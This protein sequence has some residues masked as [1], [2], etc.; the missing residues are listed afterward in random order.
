VAIGHRSEAVERASGGEQDGL[1]VTKP[2]ITRLGDTE[3]AVK[4]AIERSG[5]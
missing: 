2:G 5:G 4:A 1:L 3:A